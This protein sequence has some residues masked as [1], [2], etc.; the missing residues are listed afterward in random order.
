MLS[1]GLQKLMRQL[2]YVSLGIPVSFFFIWGSLVHLCLCKRL[3][4]GFSIG[5]VCASP[6]NTCSTESL[7]QWHGKGLIP[8]F[9]TFGF[10]LKELQLG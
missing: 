3:Q 4:I 5:K 9:G 2:L 1:L 8:A 10:S 7:V 6:G